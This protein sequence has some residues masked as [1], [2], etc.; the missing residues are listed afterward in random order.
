MVKNWEG[1]IEGHNAIY[2]A[3]VAA[4]ILERGPMVPPA[5]HLSRYLVINSAKGRAVKEPTKRKSKQKLKE[6]A[7]C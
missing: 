7:I 1:L 3:S 4:K 2:F 5:L 6:I